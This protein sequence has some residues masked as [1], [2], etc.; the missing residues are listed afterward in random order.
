MERGPRGPC[1]PADGAGFGGDGGGVGEQW[2]PQPFCSPRTLPAS[3]RLSLCQAGPG[4]LVLPL[5]WPGG[6][7][8]F[9]Y[10]TNPCGTLRPAPDRTPRGR[11]I[12]PPD[13][14]GTPR[15]APAPQG[16]HPAPQP[17]PRVA[18]DPTSSP[19]DPSGDPGVP[20]VPLSR[21][22]TP[23]HP[24]PLRGTPPHRRGEAGG[25]GGR[26]APRWRRPAHPQLRGGAS[27]SHAAGEGGA[28][29]AAPP[30]GQAVAAAAGE[31]GWGGVRHV[32]GGSKMAAPM[33]RATRGGATAPPRG[34]G[35]R[36]GAS[37]P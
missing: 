8:P 7:H 21:G 33:V 1:A 6:Q 36:G 27:R 30:D 31:L 26:E 16:P 25:G 18:Q 9:S 11:C 19:T 12:P 28:K 3:P 15:S 14:L 32:T 2:L 23:E 24:V 13:S 20:Q 37:E 29:M 34:N 10:P 4:P 5:G 17:P 35:G 22:D